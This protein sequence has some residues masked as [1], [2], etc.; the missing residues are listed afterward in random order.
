MKLV[1]RIFSLIRHKAQK[2]QYYLEI[3]AYFLRKGVGMNIGDKYQHHKG[4][5]RKPK[6]YYI[7]NL[8][9]DFANNRVNHT[10]TTNAPKK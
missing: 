6:T 9:Y 3:G 10:I 4:K 5:Q 8:H 7:A 1:L 2:K